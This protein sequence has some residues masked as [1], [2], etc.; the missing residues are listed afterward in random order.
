MICV[1]PGVAGIAP[2]LRPDEKGLVLD[3]LRKLGNKERTTDGK[4]PV[5][6]WAHLGSE[7]LAEPG[8]VRVFLNG[9]RRQTQTLWTYIPAWAN[10]YWRQC[11]RGKQ[12]QKISVDLQEKRRTAAIKKTES[13]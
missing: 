6:L 5:D 11:R 7:P 4:A 9:N 12:E 3:W 1:I 13:Q 8:H 2:L 10:L